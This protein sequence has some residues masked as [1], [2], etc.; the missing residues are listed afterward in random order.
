MEAAFTRI[1]NLSYSAGWMILAVL[2][3]RLLLKKAPRWVSV[4]L[5]GL[6]GLRLV[7]PVSLRSLELDLFVEPS[8]GFKGD[9]A[10]NSLRNLAIEARKS[11]L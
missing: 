11:D 9:P 1:F 2:V 5:W 3:F 4:L 6:V 7:M 10:Y 8:E